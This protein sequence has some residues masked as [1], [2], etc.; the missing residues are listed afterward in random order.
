MKKLL[1]KKN[2][3]LVKNYLHNYNS[4]IKLI[5]LSTTSKT[6]IDAA[7]SL[8]TT[9]G[10]IVKSLIFKDE[11]DLYYLCLISGDKFVS[12]NKLSFLL[13]QKIIKAN[14]EEVKKT[15]GFS[16]GCV[17]PVAH[18][19]IPKKIFIDLNLKNFEKIYAAAGNPYVVFKTT[20]LDLISITKAISCDIVD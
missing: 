4:N 15:T 7:N 14:A 2:V 10:S 18:K 5:E 19:N 11:N 6:A 12:I 17:P 16:I 13:N 8:K 20:Y 3:L 9:V 1:E